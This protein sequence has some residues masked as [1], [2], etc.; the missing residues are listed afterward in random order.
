[1]S[2]REIMEAAGLGRYQTYSALARAWRGGY[3]LRTRRTLYDSEHVFKGRGGSSVHTRPFHLY[4]QKP[5][6]VEDVVVGGHR[7]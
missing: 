4:M 1:M 6:G 7:M 2:C 3:V 5:E